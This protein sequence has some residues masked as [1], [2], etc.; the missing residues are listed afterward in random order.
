[1]WVLFKLPINILY[2][3][4]NQGA[5]RK[6]TEKSSISSKNLMMTA[7]INLLNTLAPFI[8]NIWDILHEEIACNNRATNEQPLTHPPTI[9]L[10]QFFLVVKMLDAIQLLLSLLRAGL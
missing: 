2:E 5:K 6:K 3:E 1:M 4:V 7:L 9:I 10:E 8:K